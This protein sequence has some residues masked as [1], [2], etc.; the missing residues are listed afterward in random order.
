MRWMKGLLQPFSTF[1]TKVVGSGGV[2]CVGVA[3]GVVDVV[4]EWS[5]REV[6]REALLALG[7]GEDKERA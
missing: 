6:A 7:Q 2:A 3:R 5:K 4:E 1:L